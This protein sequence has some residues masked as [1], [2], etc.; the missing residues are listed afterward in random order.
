MCVG[1]RRYLKK[2]SHCTLKRHD[3]KSYTC[4]AIIDGYPH[5][6]TVLITKKNMLL[7]MTKARS[8]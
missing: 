3:W 5:R 6:C 4:S 8:G 2:S 7:M 1:K